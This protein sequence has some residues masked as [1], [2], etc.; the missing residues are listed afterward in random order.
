MHR[1]DNFDNL[2]F[3]GWSVSFAPSPVYALI[4]KELW[5]FG[6][7]DELRTSVA[8]SNL[9]LGGT[10]ILPVIV[11]AKEKFT[12]EKRLPIYGTYGTGADYPH[13]PEC[14]L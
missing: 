13:P 11:I 2:F 8:P 1:G 3:R 10:G 7:T 4:R 12:P 5:E 6:A 14:E 9:F